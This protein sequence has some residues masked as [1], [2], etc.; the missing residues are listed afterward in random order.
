MPIAP[1]GF[2]FLNI[3]VLCFLYA[4]HARKSRF[5][6]V[7]PDKNEL[8]K[9]MNWN[10]SV[11][12]IVHISAHE[13]HAFSVHLW[14]KPCTAFNLNE[15]CKISIHWAW[16]KIYGVANSWRLCRQF[17]I[18]IWERQPDKSKFTHKTKSYRYDVGN[19]FM[20][21]VQTKDST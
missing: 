10:L 4:G 6:G 11:S 16:A 7:M 17:I 15:I 5:I 21:S 18:L 20:H 13:L 12:W 3:R 2:L 8:P 9:G 19:A 1:G 14:R